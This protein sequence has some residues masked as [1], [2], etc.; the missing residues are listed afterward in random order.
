MAKAGAD[1][2]TVDINGESV[3]ETAAAISQLGR[4]SLALRADLAASLK[5]I[6]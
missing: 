1:V 2:A 6:A 3:K 4:R 5:S